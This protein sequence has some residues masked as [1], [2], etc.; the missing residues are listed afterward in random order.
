MTTRTEGN[1]DQPLSKISRSYDDTLVKVIK[2]NPALV[3][4]HYASQG[5]LVSLL[6]REDDENLECDINIVIRL[7][8]DGE[9][10]KNP[11]I[12]MKEWDH[13]MGTLHGS[14]IAVVPIFQFD[15]GLHSLLSQYSGRFNTVILAVD[16]DQGAIDAAG[17]NMG[18]PP[19]R[20]L[21]AEE[22]TEI[23][24]PEVICLKGKKDELGPSFEHAPQN[25]VYIGRNMNMGGWRLPKSKWANPYP[26]KQYGR[27]KVLE[28]YRQHILQSPDLLNFLPELEGKVLACW[29]A[30]EPCHGDIL[31][32]MFSERVR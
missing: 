11:D 16:T 17:M 25:Y 1:G 10:I 23:I 8:D 21:R 28:M 18:N 14:S 30:P 32:E 24:Q 12:S 20:R 2:I 26:V 29:C 9:G 5:H 4:C 3:A 22:K 7:F 13:I 15:V 19:T 6:R 31:K 27:D